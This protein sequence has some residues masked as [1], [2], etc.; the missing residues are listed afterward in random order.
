M[1]EEEKQ[2]LYQWVE[3]GIPKG[4]PSDL[5]AKAEFVDGW[6]LGKPDM[7][8]SMPEPITVSVDGVVPYQYITIDPGFTEGKWVRAS[9]VRPGVRSV[10]HHVVVFI[11]PPGGDP[12][13]EERGFGFE[14]VG[15]YVPG[16]PP[17]ELEDGVARYVPAGSTFVFQM[18]YTPDGTEHKDQSK[19]GLYFADPATIRRTIQTGVVANLDFVI[20]PHAEN[21]AVEGAHRFSHDMELHA[22]VPHMHYRGKSFRFEVTYPN[23]SREILLDVPRYD[24]NWQNTYRLAKPKFVPEGTLLKCTAHFDNSEN[25]LSNP[26]PT[27]P[28]KW[29]EQTWEEMMIGY[30]EGVYLNQDL[31]LPQLKITPLADGDFRVRFTYQPDRPVKSVHLAGTFNEWNTS[32]H[33]FNGPDEQG[34]YTRYLR[35]KPGEYRYKFV[36]DGNYWSHDPASKI[37]TGFT[38]DSF[39]V[40]GNKAQRTRETTP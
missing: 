39:F 37:L 35:L 1:P 10:V 33:R 18:H 20:P 34:V 38:H 2:L 21:H 22:L 29:G 11:N 30:F 23:G 26:D 25:N 8:I 31:S 32:K 16:A 40:V 13:L 24:F 27:I 6:A 28:V 9:E 15:A 4:S 12:I 3:N 5:P 19:I 14:T 7:V 17:M 36:I